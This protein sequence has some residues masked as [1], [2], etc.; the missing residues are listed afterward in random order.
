MNPIY[1]ALDVPSESEAVA[2]ASDLVDVVG[3]F[4][5]GL[6]L[7]MGPGPRLVERLVGLGLPVFCDA[8]LHDIPHTVERAAH[9]IGKLGARWVTVH[10]SGGVTQLEAAVSGLGEADAGT[11]V[12]AVTVLTSMDAASLAEVGISEAPGHQ[13]RRL[14]GLAASAGVEGIVCS[15]ADLADVGAAAPGLVRVT[16]GVRPPGSDRGDQRRVMTP[17]NAIA[18]G[19]DLL[20]V[21]RPITRADDPVEAAAAIARS[22]GVA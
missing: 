4:K 21:G 5:V 1:V 3:G 8:K 10:A 16:P 18:A 12:L 9:Q 17:E 13:V 6:E 11:G 2:L 22:V 15:A 7:L 19:A 20:V 14:A